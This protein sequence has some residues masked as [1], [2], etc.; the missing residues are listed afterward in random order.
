MRSGL[1]KRAC[2]VIIM[3]AV[4]L[5]AGCV[6]GGKSYVLTVQVLGSDQEPLEG[7]SVVVGSVTEETDS[8]GK[9]VFAKVFG[10]VTIEVTAED[11][12]PASASVT[13]TK[14]HTETMILGQ[15]T[16]DV[17]AVMEAFQ[18]EGFSLGD[19]EDEEFFDQL[20]RAFAYF[21]EPF[22]F[23]LTLES[24]V[25]EVEMA[26]LNLGQR[27]YMGESFST[28]FF[29]FYEEGWDRWE[30]LDHVRGSLGE[31]EI[32]V[33]FLFGFIDSSLDG[34]L[35]EVA[36]GWRSDVSGDDSIA[37]VEH[38]DLDTSLPVV[39]LSGSSATWRQVSSIESTTTTMDEEVLTGTYTLTVEVGLIKDVEWQIHEIHVHLLI[40]ETLPDGLAPSFLGPK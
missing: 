37:S 39:T 26:P 8:E 28:E 19:S 36:D 24:F 1:S 20:P 38:T 27:I 18:A 10:Q 13:V 31:Y 22:L 21:T 11:Y 35:Q 12:L 34:F 7:A 17:E 16:A 5:L 15:D 32:L 9:V 6:G 33:T 3:L 14:D 2:V 4:A 25:E 29:L 40:D 23:S 30:Y